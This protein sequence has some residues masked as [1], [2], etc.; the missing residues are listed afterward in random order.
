MRRHAAVLSL[1]LAV[2]AGPAGA[3]E[4]QET[5][6]Q[7][8][9]RLADTYQITNA[10]GDRAC[11]VSLVPKTARLTTGTHLTAEQ[12]QNL[13]EVTLDKPG[14][15]AR[16]A[17]TSDIAAWA[18]GPG[19]SIRLYGPSGALI[20]EFTE[21]V[22][23]TWEAL[24]ERDGVYFLVNPR[25]VDTT[26]QAQ[27]S[28]VFGVWSLSRAIGTPG[29]TVM[30]G[31]TPLAN[32]DYPLHPDESCGKVFGAFDPERWRLDQGDLMLISPDG[33]HLRF[34]AQDEGGWSKV[35]EDKRPLVLHRTP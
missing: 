24:R 26:T 25:L 11:P 3:Q 17:F 10:D 14:C 32:G 8:A 12:R 19:D 7:A 22:G 9:A 6:A 30:F 33:E 4:T 31:E 23:G 28:D 2:T 13:F 20:A 34:A 15:A 5:T 21:G 16:I 27:P 1:A 18:P 35:P 29:C